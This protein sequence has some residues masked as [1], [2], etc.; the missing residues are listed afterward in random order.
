[1][2]TTATTTTMSMGMG[3]VTTRGKERMI[4]EASHE[5][6]PGIRWVVKVVYGSHIDVNK[7]RD[8]MGSYL[9]VNVDEEAKRKIRMI[10]R[11]VLITTRR[12]TSTAFILSFTDPG[13]HSVRHPGSATSAPGRARSTYND[14]ALKSPSVRAMTRNPEQWTRPVT[15][16]IRSQTEAPNVSNDPAGDHSRRRWKLHSSGR[17]ISCTEY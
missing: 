11:K 6:F 3:V 16:A 7:Y 12:K 8:K 10:N 17:Q 15:R 5:L 13:S 4:L 2:S 14:A 1:M 9:K